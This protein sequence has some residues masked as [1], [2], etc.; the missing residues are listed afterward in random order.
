MKNSSN[1]TGTK[2]RNIIYKTKMHWIAYVKP[3][4]SIIVSI[5][6]ILLYIIIFWGIQIPSFDFWG[7]I[8]FIIPLILVLWI[9]RSVISIIYYKLAKIYITNR[10]VTLET[11]IL[12]KQIDDIE[13]KKYEGMS[14]HQSF[15]GRVLNYG[16]LT[17]STG[18]ISQSYQIEKP[19]IFRENILDLINN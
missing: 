2:E 4:V 17:I 8:N 16:M 7:I 12:S 19:L 15:L 5:F 1:V 14:I 11:G 9:A 13:L 3:T 6:L 10:G 18:E